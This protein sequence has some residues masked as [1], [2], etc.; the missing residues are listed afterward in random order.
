MSP[1]DFD[2]LVQQAH[3]TQVDD[4]N[5]FRRIKEHVAD[6]EHRAKRDEYAQR[7]Q[8]G[9][10]IKEKGPTD[11]VW[12]DAQGNELSDDFVSGQEL[13]HHINNQVIEREDQEAQAEYDRVQQIQSKAEQDWHKERSLKE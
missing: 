13:A 11:Y 10:S 2:E 6:R 5:E 1:E 9:Q 8:N 3:Q 4:I 7:I 12:V